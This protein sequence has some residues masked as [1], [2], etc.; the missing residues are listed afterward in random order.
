MKKIYFVGIGMGNI[1]TLTE[2]GRK[3]IEVQRS[4]SSARREW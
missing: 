1:E 4:C 3:A 2:Q